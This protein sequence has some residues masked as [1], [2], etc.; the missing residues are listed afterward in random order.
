MIKKLLVLGLIVV[1]GV[2]VFKKTNVTSYASTL[3]SNGV[4][5]ISSQVP[6]EFEI[7]RVRREISRLDGDIRNHLGPIAEKMAQIKKLDRDIQSARVNLKEQREHLLALTK[8]VDT[9][10]QLIVA[11]G[12]ELT[13]EQGKNRLAR[14]FGIF[15]RGET[16]LKSQERLLEAQRK[17][18]GSTHEQLSKMMEQKR[19][20]EIRLAQLEA[21]EAELKLARITTPLRVDDSR[22]ADIRRTLDSIEQGQEVD[23]AELQL[24]QQYGSK[25]TPRL[26][27]SSQTAPDV[28]AIRS[29]LEGQVAVAERSAAS[30]K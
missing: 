25:L 15:K 4:S 28:A 13:L 9:G 29:Y 8:S 18:L 10:E 17:N 2:W 7:D 26:N 1:A 19:E 23:Q 24:L 30:S 22:F 27:S 16:H 11:D 20:F 5:C 3:W 21:Q 12:E 6:R 14:E